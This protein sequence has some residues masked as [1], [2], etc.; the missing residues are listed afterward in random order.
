MAKGGVIASPTLALMGEYTGANS[1][2]EIAVPQNT[3]K[4]TFREEMSDFFANNSNNGQPIRVQFY[5]GTKMFIDEVVDGINEK[6]RQTG[7][8]QI[9]V[10]YT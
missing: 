8:A 2:P 6:T 3:L 4:S 7:K 1:N 10:S 5:L 9:K